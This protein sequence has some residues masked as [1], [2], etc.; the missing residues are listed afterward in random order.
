MK[1]YLLTIL[2][3]YFY[4]GVKAQ[5]YVQSGATLHIGG[6]VTLQ[7]EDFIRSS[8]SGPAIVFEPDSKVLFTGNADNV[9]SGYIGFLNLEI[10][11]EGSHQVSLQNYNEEVN[12]E[13]TFTSGFFNLNNNTLL[14]GSSGTLINENENSRIIGP[15]GGAVQAR[16]ELNQ[17]DN[18]NPGN[19]GA[20]ITSAKDLGNVSINRGDVYAFGLPPNAV[21][22]YYSINFVN[23]ENDHDLDATLKLS[24][25][26]AE[27]AGTDET[28]LVHWKFDSFG[29]TWMEQGPPENITRNTDE[30]WV[31]LTGNN[32]LFTWTLAESSIALPVEV[33]FFKIVCGGNTPVLK[34]QTATESNTAFF[35]VQKSEDGINWKTIASVRAAGQSSALKDYSYSDML[36][37]AS[38]E[39]FYRIQSV[40]IDGKENYTAVKTSACGN[41][42]AWQLWPNPVQQQLNINLRLNGAYKVLVQLFDNKGSVV[43]R[44]R[45]ELPGGNNQFA[46]DMHNLPAGAYHLFL[47]WDNGREQR[48]ANILKQ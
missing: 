12:G 35:A 43:R 29:N 17:P 11:K 34:W 19:I 47:T 20:T 13:M 42:A 15:T 8:P 37:A 10:D 41:E 32:S 36:P 30:N 21:Q 26:D 1:K 44:W 3:I 5:L 46:I 7:N 22:R 39:I 40:D 24:Y 25:F 48:N 23:T 28:K 9:I 33:T 6:V 38:G 2:F 18:L 4:A 14:L 16:L 31:Q 27:L 45:K